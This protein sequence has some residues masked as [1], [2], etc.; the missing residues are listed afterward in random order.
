M[1]IRISHSPKRNLVQTS[2]LLSVK[3]K[4]SKHHITKAGTVKNDLGQFSVSQP[5]GSNCVC[6]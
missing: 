5:L 1:L 6:I 2:K 3:M 4:S